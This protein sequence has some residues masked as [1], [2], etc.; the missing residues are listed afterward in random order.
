FPWQALV[1]GNLQW[2]AVDISLRNQDPTHAATIAKM[3]VPKDSKDYRDFL[4]YGQALAAD[5]RRA[6]AEQQLRKANKMAPERG[7]AC[8]A[9]VRFAVG[10]GQKAQAEAAVEEARGLVSADELSLTLA[11]CYEALG[12]NEQAL[13]Q[14]QEAVKARPDDLA[15]LRGAILFHQ[16]GGRLADAESLLRLVVDGEGKGAGADPAWA[17]RRRA[18][19]LAARRAPR[20][21]FEALR[22]VG[23]KV[24]DG[25]KV[26]P[27]DS[28]S[29]SVAVDEQRA[30]AQVLATQARKAFREPA[31]ALLEDLGKR[32]AQTTDD[33]FLLARLYEAGGD[34]PKAVERLRAVATGQSKNPAA[35]AASAQL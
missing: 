26:V 17:R 23:L 30:R 21:F 4:W 8:V 6:E 25:G 13:R 27:I 3:A 2:V 20:Q 34:L 11:R 31:I 32:Q 1:A 12:R 7:E 35:L 10:V 18:L 14:Y 24:D 9:L 33:Q 15:V 16:H 22:L 28:S 29:T 5:G 19:G